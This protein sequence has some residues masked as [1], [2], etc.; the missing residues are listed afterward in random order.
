MKYFDKYVDS[1]LSGVWL[2]SM[3]LYFVQNIESSLVMCGCIT[4]VCCYGKCTM[5]VAK[6]NIHGSA[7]GH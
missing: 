5:H 1:V 6:S 3:S 2:A 7:A 4:Y